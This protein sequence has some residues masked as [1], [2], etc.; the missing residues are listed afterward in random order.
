MLFIIALLPTLAAWFIWLKT[1]RRSL[2]GARKVLFV[3]GLSVLSIALIEYLFFEIHIYQIGGFG[4]NFPA[5]LRWARIGLWLSL[6]ALLL[7][8]SG[9]GK[10]RLIALASSLL[11]FIFWIIPVWGM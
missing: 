10:S 5:M 2:E 8:A 11:V 7:A 6:L 3:I 9:R 1:D 4:T